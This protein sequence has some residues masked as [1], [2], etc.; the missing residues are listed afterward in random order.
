MRNLDQT[1]KFQTKMS[2]IGEENLGYTGETKRYNVEDVG[3]AASSSTKD[4]KDASSRNKDTSSKNISDPNVDEVNTNPIV[5]V[6]SADFI[7]KP[8]SIVAGSAKIPNSRFNPFRKKSGLLN[9][10]AKQGKVISIPIKLEY[11]ALL[12][13]TKNLI[14]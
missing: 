13:Y 12:K 7:T 14:N 11:I 9:V 8:F 6:L 5:D 2:G 3:G 10:L 4:D 1:C